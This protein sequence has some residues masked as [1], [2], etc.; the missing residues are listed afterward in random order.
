M[1]FEVDRTS[2]WIF[3]EIGRLATGRLSRSSK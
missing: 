1:I 3:D 2:Q